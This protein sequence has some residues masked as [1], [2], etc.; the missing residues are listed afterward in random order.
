MP[1]YH[2]PSFRDLEIQVMD[3][4]VATSALLDTP[5][6]QPASVARLIALDEAIVA[7][8]RQVEEGQS[9]SVEA[10]KLRELHGRM[11]LMQRR[12]STD[13]T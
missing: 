11:L 7:E 5:K 9:E 10:N 4:E 1:G 2:K 12:I 13:K 8:L 3:A 6:L